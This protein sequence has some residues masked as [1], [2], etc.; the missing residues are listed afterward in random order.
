M[1]NTKF[2]N[3]RLYRGD[4]LDGLQ[5]QD[6]N[7]VTLGFTSPPYFNA[8]N[9]DE[10]VATMDTD[11]TWEREDMTYDA[12]KEFL[13]ERFEA[14]FRVTKPGGHTIVNLSPIHWNDERIPIPFHFVKWMEDVGWTFRED[15]VWE[16]PVAKDRRSGVLL[17]HPYP[18]YYYPS[19]VAEY[20]LVF[21]K[22][23]SSERKNNIY[24]DRSDAEKEQNKIDLDGYQ[25]EK[26]KNV[27]KI[28]PVSPSEIDHPAPFPQ[29][30]AERV[31]EFY[32]YEDDTVMD[33]FA[34]SGQTL[35]AAQN[36]DR[37]F[38]GFETQ[39]QYVEYATDRLSETTSAHA[40][41]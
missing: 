40:D 15:I 41:E 34:G 2:N 20:I 28:R 14:V 4:C 23:A 35:I 1:H 18:G 9:Y 12:Y 10:H 21:Q 38:L 31:I 22:D 33:I 27:W 29:E 8:V 6:T 5:E 24:W 16:K 26:S 19:V 13:I 7:S 32:S 37:Q 3:G 11:D 17:Q 39:Q 30:L 36:L 25:G